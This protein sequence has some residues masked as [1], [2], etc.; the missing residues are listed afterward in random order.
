MLDSILKEYKVATLF[1]VPV[2]IH[3]TTMAAIAMVV[4]SLIF[5]GFLTIVSTLMTLAL[6]ATCVVA[7]EFGHIQAARHFGI[8]TRKV[9]LFPIGGIAYIRGAAKNATEELTI[10]AGGPLVNLL[11]VLI[12]TPFIFFTP[13]ANYN[14]LY[15]LWLINLVMAIFNLIPAYP[16]D[17]GRILRGV[18]WC[19]MNEKKA[20]KIAAN[21]GLGFGFLFFLLGLSSGHM[22]LGVIGIFVFFAARKEI[23]RCNGSILP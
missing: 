5:S 16:M 9:V 21:I 15:L 6:I 22:I 13:A 8:D 11:I 1:K 18:L 4:L 7:H 12:T 3:G 17:G 2:Y 20:T 19:F 14:P 23:D 10:A